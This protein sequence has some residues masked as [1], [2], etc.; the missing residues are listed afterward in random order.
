M[1]TAAEIA[2][3][4]LATVDDEAGDSMSNLK[5]Q[6]LV[7]YAQGFH[8]ALTGKPLFNDPIMAWEHGPVVPTLY[9][10]FKQHGGEPIPR[11]EN[12]VDESNY[13]KE[14]REILNEVFDEYGQFSPWKL[15]NLTHEEPPWREAYPTHGEISQASMRRYFSTLVHEQTA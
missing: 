11:P 15:R 2:D 9:H 4:F 3:Y 14:V 12:G 1:H 7:Y 10:G 5:L 6:K 8:L 13:S